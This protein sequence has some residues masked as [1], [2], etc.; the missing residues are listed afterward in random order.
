[1]HLTDLDRLKGYERGAVD[2]ISVPVVP[3]LLRAKVSV[4]A[5]LHRK[6]H[7]LEMLNAE[8]RRLSGSLI[9]TQDEERRRIARELH[10]GLGQE[11]TRGQR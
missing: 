1:M 7:Q 2:Y 5:E 6:S 9:A 11:L 4:F 8:L 3:E 10:D